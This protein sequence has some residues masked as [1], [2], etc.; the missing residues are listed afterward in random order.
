L[1]TCLDGGFTCSF[2]CQRLH[3]LFCGINCSAR[4]S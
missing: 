2:S 3:L 4:S 1:E